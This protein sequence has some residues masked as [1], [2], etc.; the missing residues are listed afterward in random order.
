MAEIVF[1][2]KKKE[3]NTI[4]IEFPDGTIKTFEILGRTV[5]NQRK[6][7]DVVNQSKK[8]KSDDPDASYK[9]LDK[10]ISVLMVG[11]SLKDFE[12][13]DTEDIFNMIISIKDSILGVELRDDTEKKTVSNEPM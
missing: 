9:F 11:A 4:K 12:D 6:V 13:F 8:I 3:K 7:I 5:E 10:T 2:P 1:R